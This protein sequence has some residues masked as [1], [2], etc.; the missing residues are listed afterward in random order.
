MNLC[1]RLATKSDP[2]EVTLVE[3][4]QGCIAD[5]AELLNLDSPSKLY[6]LRQLLDSQGLFSG[7]FSRRFYFYFFIFYFLAE[8]NF[9]VLLFC[10]SS[11]ALF[12][13]GR[14]LDHRR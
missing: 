3:A 1:V 4:Q 11:F 13:C 12:D 8:S 10:F 14:R 9:V 2:G 7:Q 6:D 5:G